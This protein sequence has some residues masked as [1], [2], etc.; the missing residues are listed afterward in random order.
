MLAAN[1]SA[2]SSTFAE[3]K[4]GIGSPERPC[5]NEFGEPKLPEIRVLD[6]AAGQLIIG[7]SA[8]IDFLASPKNMRVLSL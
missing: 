1:C 3:M 5:A 8:S 6:N 2:K 7:S 4:A